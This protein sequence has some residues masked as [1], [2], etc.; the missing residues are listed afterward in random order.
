MVLPF[1]FLF[2]APVNQKNI[3]EDKINYSILKQLVNNYDAV[4]DINLYKLEKTYPESD[5]LFDLLKKINPNDVINDS[6]FLQITGELLEKKYLA[7]RQ[8]SDSPIS[9]YIYNVSIWIIQRKSTQ[10]IFNVHRGITLNKKYN[11]IDYVSMIND[12]YCI[13][14]LINLIDVYSNRNAN[15]LECI[16]LLDNRKTG[17]C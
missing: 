1:L 7:I 16:E 6:L 10:Y 14:S 17:G 4:E 2:C 5:S 13:D 12:F 15:H 9:L 8:T 11:A 3:Q